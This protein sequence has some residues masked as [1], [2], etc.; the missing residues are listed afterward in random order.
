[1]AIAVSVFQV[2]D[3]GAVFGVKF[4]QLLKWVDVSGYTFNESNQCIPAFQHSSKLHASYHRI[5]HCEPLR[6]RLV[7]VRNYGSLVERLP[8]PAFK[9]LQG[10]A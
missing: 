10:S 8:H 1:M 9:D 2:P 5:L 6:F 4:W 3:L 7:R